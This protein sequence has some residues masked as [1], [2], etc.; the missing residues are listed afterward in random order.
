M[1]FTKV[2]ENSLEDVDVFELISSLCDREQINSIKA[3]SFSE[4]QK[5]I[6]LEAISKLNGLV[7]LNLSNLETGKGKFHLRNEL[8][9]VHLFNLQFLNISNN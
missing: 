3:M 5:I 4:M 2:K 7:I 6:N 1:D 8:K 9:K